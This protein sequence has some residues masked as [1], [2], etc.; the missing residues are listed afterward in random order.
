MGIYE[1][2]RVALLVC[3]GAFALLVLPAGAWRLTGSGRS[4][5]LAG[6][7]LRPLLEAIKGQQCPTVEHVTPGV[8]PTLVHKARRI[9]S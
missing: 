5:A 9:R 7:P 2:S 1:K 3:M 4:G 6:L 8:T